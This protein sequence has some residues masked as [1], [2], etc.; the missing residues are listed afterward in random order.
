MPEIDL[1]QLKRDHQ[2]LAR[3]HIDARG[4]NVGPPVGPRSAARSKQVY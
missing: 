3:Q 4:Q 1:A 2:L